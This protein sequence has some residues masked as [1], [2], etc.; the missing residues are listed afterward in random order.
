[1]L[2]VF[3]NLTVKR[4]ADNFLALTTIQIINYIL[5]LFLI[6]FLI[7]ALGMEGYGIYIFIFTIAG[8]GIKFS[9]Y[10]FDLSATYQ[11][12][13][14]KNNYQKINEIFSSVLIIKLGLALLFLT[15][16]SIAI[17]SIELLYNYKELLFL[18]YG[19]LVGNLLLPL[20]FFQGIEKMRFIMY[21]NGLLKLSFFI[22]VILYVKSQEELYLLMLFHSVTAIITGILGLF[23][24]IKYFNIKFIPINKKIILF[25]LKDGCYIFTSK[26]AVEF[27]STSSIIIVGFFV[28]PLLLGYY[29]VSIKIMLAIGNLFDPITRVVYPYFIGLYQDSN[30]DFLTR[31]KQLS[32]LILILMIPIALLVFMFAEQILQF[33]TNK[34]VASLNIYLLKVT[35]LM[36][37]VIPYGG[38]FT[39]MLITMKKTKVLNNILMTAAAIN[40][41]FAP[42]VL[43]FYSLVGMIWLNTFISYFLMSIKAYWI[44]K[45]R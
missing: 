13:I 39:N 3:N 2:T 5:P 36:L 32:V 14:H 12:S 38:Q 15:L 35:A 23:L 43:H 4:L 28:S 40:L 17:F 41:I 26:L 29:A 1:M 42:I 37:L 30:K 9:D 6:P 31:N 27:Y 22:L 16:L 34:E 44:Y 18:S 19:M 33:I 10:G 7:Q 11:V 45:K 24:A 20:W 25:Y 8:Y 21:L